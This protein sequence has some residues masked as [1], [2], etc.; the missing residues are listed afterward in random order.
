MT[1]SQKVSERILPAANLNKQTTQNRLV[2]VVTVCLNAHEDL[3]K[4]IDSVLAQDHPQIEYLIIDGGSTD[5][6]LEIIR[7][8]A[9]RIDYWHSEPDLGVYHAMN[10]AVRHCSGEWVLF[11]NAGDTFSAPDSLSRMFRMAP[12]GADVVYGHHL[13]VNDGKEEYHPAADFD[14]TWAR[15]QKGKLGFDWLAGIPGHQATA[16]RKTLLEKLKFDTNF[17]IAADHDL[18]FRARGNGAKFFNCDEIISIY[19]GGGFS[20]KNYDR[21]KMEWRQIAERHGHARRARKFYAELDEAE[22]RAKP[23]DIA[24]AV[25]LASGFGLPEGPYTNEKLPSFRWMLH[26][27]ARIKIKRVR[28]NWLCLKMGTFLPGQVVTVTA[29][30]E[31]IDRIKIHPLGWRRQF[32]Y[33]YIDL[34]KAGAN[35]EIEFTFSKSLTDNASR[36]ISVMLVDYRL[37]KRLSL[38]DKIRKYLSALR[39]R[40][41]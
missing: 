9:E 24:G 5:G 37:K 40:L 29:A 22:E 4:T 20:A 18:L 39:S 14:S 19:V 41:S 1:P 30:G 38:E 15:L 23:A 17:R 2:S 12:K 21:C 11:M 31:E 28:V 10:D 32:K 25:E 36:D 34:S 6:T 13:Y 27:R 26:P 8:N 35:D 33:V 7:T 3:Q 16:V